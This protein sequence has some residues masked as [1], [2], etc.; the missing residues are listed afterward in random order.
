M[1]STEQY[2]LAVRCSGHFLLPMLL[3]LS[4][5]VAAGLFVVL[6]AFPGFFGGAIQNYKNPALESSS[7]ANIGPGVHRELIKT[8]LYNLQADFYAPNL[9]EFVAEG[10]AIALFGPNYLVVD[11]D[12]RMHRFG[13]FPDSNELWIK[14]LP[15]QVPLNGE[16]LDH[17]NI[18]GLRR[19]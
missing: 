7:Q 2:R 11:G 13:W 12:G 4:V 8:S 16:A 3:A 9:P 19:E 10:G 18:S 5:V 6:F 14:P 1:S 17:A 15:Y